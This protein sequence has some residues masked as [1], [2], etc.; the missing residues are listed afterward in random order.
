MAGRILLSG[1]SSK[2]ELNQDGTVYLKVLEWGDEFFILGTP[3][4]S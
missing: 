3:L 4:P 1:V 2:Y